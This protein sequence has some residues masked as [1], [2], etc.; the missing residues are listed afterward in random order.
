MHLQHPKSI[1]SVKIYRESPARK[2]GLFALCVVAYA[3]S[4]YACS[5]T[6]GVPYARALDEAKALDALSSEKL[7]AKAAAHAALD[8]LLEFRLL[9][10]AGG[11]PAAIRVLLVPRVRDRAE[12]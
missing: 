11:E 1:E 9:G 8:E 6:P 7:S 5:A 10:G 3:A 4:F 12:Q 2:Y